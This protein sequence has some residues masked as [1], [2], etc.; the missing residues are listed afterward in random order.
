[1]NFSAACRYCLILLAMLLFTHLGCSSSSSS[2]PAPSAPAATEFPSPDAAVQALVDALRKQDRP[3]LTEMLIP[4]ADDI[5]YSGDKA[6]D[7]AEAA[8]FL[9]LYDAGHRIQSDGKGVSTLLVGAGD[10]PFPVPIVKTANGYAFDAETGRDEILNRRIGRNEL[11]A[12]QVC[13]AVVDAEREYV[14][15]RPTGSALPVYAQKFISDTG[16][17]N[18]LYWPTSE[19]EQQSPL[20]PLAAEAAAEYSA[21][22]AATTPGEQPHPYRGYCYRLLTSQ[23]P[24]ARGGALDYMVNG[25]LIG[26]FA[27]V[28]YPAQYGNSGIVTFITN[29]DGIVYQRDLGPDTSQLARAMKSFDP[30][31]E[32]T[33]TTAAT[34]P[35]QVD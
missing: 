6:A 22:T 23:G 33:K 4:A 16:K 28:A 18:G 5:L 10:W 20:G 13:L 8:R 9:A 11:G 25:Q 14:V 17:K 27:V 1:M 2:T 35:T 24:H 31:P 15:R 19:G 34:Q 32:W 7:Q 30:G 21:S 26:G 12:Q 29:H 3:R